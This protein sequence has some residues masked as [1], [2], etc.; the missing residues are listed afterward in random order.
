MKHKT[1]RE[2]AWKDSARS[3]NKTAKDGNEFLCMNASF[4][5]PC[6]SCQFFFRAAAFEHIKAR[7]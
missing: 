5:S 4:S 6:F 7:K 3:L 2:I 1:W